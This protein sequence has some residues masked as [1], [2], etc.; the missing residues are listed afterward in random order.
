MI[1]VAKHLNGLLRPT[2]GL[3]TAQEWQQRAL[4]AEQ[5]LLLIAS[6]A[7]AL[8]TENTRLRRNYRRVKP[9]HDQI[10]QRAAADVRLMLALA[11]AGQETTRRRCADELGISRRRW[12]WARALARLAGIHDGVEFDAL[13]TDDAIRR[14]RSAAEKAQK[15]PALL[16]KFL[17]GAGR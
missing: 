1:D 13:A 14:L 12:D 16:R 11:L 7:A 5:K 3:Q 15:Q 8:R 4:L 10:V 6:Q 17:P 2:E 9:D